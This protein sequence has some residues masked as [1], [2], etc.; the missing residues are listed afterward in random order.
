MNEDRNGI[1]SLRAA[2]EAE[3]AE[4]A[5]ATSDGR[6][7]PI[8]GLW[9]VHLAAEMR[10]FAVEG[11]EKR[12]G[13]LDVETTL[14]DA[15]KLVEV[16]GT[17]AL[18]GAAVA[19]YEMHVGETRGAD[20]ARPFLNL[21]SGPDGAIL[22]P[23]TPGEILVRGL[24]V[25]PG[26]WQAPEATAKTLKDGW[27]H[28][29]DVGLLDGDGYLTL[30]DRSKDMIISGGTNIYPRE[31]EE[32]LL[33]HAGVRECAVI[34]APHPDWGEEVVAFVVRQSGGTDDAGVPD[35]NDLDQL[36][37]SRI[38]R[39]KRPKRKVSTGLTGRGG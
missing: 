3:G 17:D 24:P 35:A 15:K 21:S 20:T 6:K 37:L 32:V 38:A 22:P 27:L 31:I 1:D 39:F 11:I 26:Y 19:G 25:M 29:G 16:S 23:G 8:I 13:L 14:S 18:S 5:C 7:H 34:G 30:V 4:M 9:P 2:I 12:L 10:D 28:T 36:C 33:T